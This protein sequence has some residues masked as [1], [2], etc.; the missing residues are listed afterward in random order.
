MYASSSEQQ[1]RAQVQALAGQIY[2]AHRDRLLAIARRNSDGVEQAEEA[3]QDA[4]T[5]FIEHFDTA[6]GA[7]PLA[8]LTLTLKRRCWAL[9]RLQRRSWQQCSESDGECSDTE[10][11]GGSSRHLDDLLDLAEE[12]ASTRSR[13]AELKRDERRAL[14]LL[15]LGYSYRE[16]GQITGWTYTKT[17]RCTAEGRAALR[18]MSTA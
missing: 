11:L 18:K 6:S 9:Y 10:L 14:S 5:L 4:F 1:R 15:A 7:P 8:W 2:D 17:N 13:L 3:L 16:I 12:V